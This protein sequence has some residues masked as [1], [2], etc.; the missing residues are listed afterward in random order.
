MTREAFDVSERFRVPVMVRLVT[1]L[2]HSRSIVS[3]GEARRRTRSRRRR[4][5]PWILLPANARRQWRDLLDRQAA[6][7][8]PTRRDVAVEHPHARRR[9]TNW[10]SSRPA[11]RFNYFLENAGRPRDRRRSH[12]HIGAYPLPVRRCGDRRTREAG[13]SC[14][15][16]ATRTRAA[17]ARAAAG[18]RRGQG[19]ESGHL[20]G[21]RR[22]DARRRARGARARRAAAW[23]SASFEAAGRPPQLCAGCPHGDTYA[24]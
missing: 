18:A 9:S 14:S 12:L 4:T 8:A 21:R 22:A 2:A 20:P 16:T 11:S 23:R 17:A 19:R 6:A 5:A 10:A 13:C 24:R 1:R 15:R 7:C 3:T